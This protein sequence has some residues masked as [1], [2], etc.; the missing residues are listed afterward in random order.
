MEGPPAH[1]AWEIHTGEKRSNWQ[2]E[3]PCW[4]GQNSWKNCQVTKIKEK[5][6]ESEQE[7]ME[8]EEI[9]ISWAKIDGERLK[10]YT[11]YNQGCLLAYTLPLGKLEKHASSSGREV[12]LCLGAQQKVGC[13]LATICFPGWCPCVRHS[14][15]TVRGG[16]VYT[17]QVY[18]LKSN[19]TTF[20]M[21]YLWGKK[22]I[23][24]L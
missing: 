13:I 6:E 1:W 2:G 24:C 15:H 20:S 11:K 7:G 21:S 9:R 3:V 14:L 17:D 23:V 19:G 12:V 4:F 16:S 10:K 5:Q 18:A 22:K 8:V